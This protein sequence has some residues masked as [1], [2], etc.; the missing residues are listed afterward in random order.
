MTTDRAPLLS[1]EKLELL[2]DKEQRSIYEAERATL[3][4]EIDRLKAA[5][6]NWEAFRKGNPF[7]SAWD[8]EDDKERSYQEADH[9]SPLPVGMGR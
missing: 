7:L 9:G 6:A 3:F 4:A 2:S 8:D 1:D 5:L